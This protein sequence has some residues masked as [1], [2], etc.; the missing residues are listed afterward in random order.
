[1]GVEQFQAIL[2]FESDLLFLVVNGNDDG[3]ERIV[4]FLRVAALS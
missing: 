1:M 4:S 2:Q 3:D